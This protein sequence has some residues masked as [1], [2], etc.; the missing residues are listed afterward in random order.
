MYYVE[1][2]SRKPDVDPERFRETVTRTLRLW[3]A[4]NPPPG[5]GAATITISEGRATD[6]F[7]DVW[8]PADG[9]I[10]GVARPSRANGALR[11]QTIGSAFSA[12]NPAEGESESWQAGDGTR[13]RDP[14][15]R[16]ACSTD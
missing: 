3:A 13:A 4:R 7:A 11:P 8:N 9:T 2:Y 1:V 15:L 12:H 14:R 10:T 16:G 6:G 5:I